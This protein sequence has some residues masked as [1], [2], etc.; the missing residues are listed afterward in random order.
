MNSVDTEKTK[1]P[2]SDH[3]ING[4]LIEAVITLNHKTYLDEPF[5]IAGLTAEEKKPNTRP[6]SGKPFYF[7]D[8]E[9]RSYTVRLLLPSYKSDPVFET[10]HLTE[11][12]PIELTVAARDYAENH[13]AM[14]KIAEGMEQGYAKPLTYFAPLELHSVNITAT[15][16]RQDKDGYLA[17]KGGE[18]IGI[19]F[20][21]SHPVLPGQMELF[22]GSHLAQPQFSEKYAEGVY[23]YTARYITGEAP[24]LELEDM[25]KLAPVFTVGDLMGQSTKYPANYQGENQK[26][27]PRYYAPIEITDVTLS[28]SNKKDETL[29]AKDEDTVYV[30]FTSNHFLELEGSIAGRGFKVS[31]KRPDYGSEVTEWTLSYTLAN[32]DLQ[33][34]EVVPFSFTAQ[35]ITGN[36][37][38]RYTNRSQGVKNELVY[39]EPLEA[40]ASIASSN[41]R[42]EYA[43]NGDTITV[44]LEAQHKTAPAEASIGSRDLAGN[45]DYREK[46]EV[47][48]SLPGGESTI[49]EG[50]LFFTVMLE[51]AA[52]NTLSVSETEDE[53]K[54]TYDR[55]APEVSILPGFDGVTN[56]DVSLSLLY[57][58]MYIDR[59]TLSCTVNESE[60][61]ASGEK[62]NPAEPSVTFTQPLSISKEGEYKIEGN[63]FD[64]AGNEAEFKATCRFIIDKTGPVLQFDP[65]PKTYAAGFYLG[66]LF[67]IEEELVKEVACTLT[68]G[69]GVH[70]WALEAPIEAEGKK[71]VTFMAEDLAG[72]AAVPITCDFYIDATAPLPTVHETQRGEALVTEGENVITEAGTTL[73]IGLARLH[74]GDETP[75]RFTRLEL[76]DENGN[77]AQNLLAGAAAA[78]GSYTLSLPALGRYT[79]VAQAAD[80]VDNNTGLLSFPINY[81]EMYW[82]ELAL[83]GTPLA[84]LTW[85]RDVTN[86]QLMLVGGAFVLLAGAAAALPLWRRH[87]RKSRQGKAE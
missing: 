10:I 15:E 19:E 52:G 40:T 87:S 17:V 12:G 21:T 70:D 72:N 13:A 82:L 59:E 28:S 63:V 25:E 50:E 77:L 6:Q 80:D 45:L 26:W 48:L 51:D 39:Y 41:K 71:T 29:F 3:A 11:N 31:S 2:D 73:V 9:T 81:R 34:L 79:L 36:E 84:G 22:L 69:E 47:T 8:P 76:L 57:S 58:D 66:R 56:R 74:L 78:D 32:K 83:Q 30:N 75:D 4:S 35:D 37:P 62:T 18:E 7:Y 55:T 65:D 27:T 5:T 16:M 14:Q 60:R 85:V 43:K 46:P 20:T 68:D 53:S 54:V 86:M 23:T 33:D 44:S 67:S 38:V 64:M 49:S 1:T 42:P 24:L 61:V